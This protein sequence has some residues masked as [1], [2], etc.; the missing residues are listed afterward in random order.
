MVIE[1]LKADCEI[2]YGETCGPCEVGSWRSGGDYVCEEGTREILQ[3][4]DP[5][6][7]KGISEKISPTRLGE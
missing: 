6:F 5:T 3:S 4:V 1:S 2:E 7:Y